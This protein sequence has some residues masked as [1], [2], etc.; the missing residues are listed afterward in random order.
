MSSSTPEVAA[1]LRAWASGL[2]PLEAAV[3]L[4]IR[5]WDGRLLHGPWIVVEVDGLDTQVWFDPTP[6]AEATMS[7]GERRVLEIAGSLASPEYPIALTDTVSGLDRHALDL[8]LAAIAH[9][10]GSHDQ[11]DMIVDPDT[12][13]ASFTPRPSL[14]PWPAE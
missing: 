13:K 11:A 9:A 8:V 14:Y 6:I 5:A 1:G 3:E 4:L 10:G 2:H 12:G 7:G